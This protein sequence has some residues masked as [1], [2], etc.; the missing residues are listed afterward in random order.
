MLKICNNWW[1]SLFFLVLSSTLL[2]SLSYLLHLHSI[3]LSV[4]FRVCGIWI[5]FSCLLFVASTVVS[6][7]AHLLDQLDLWNMWGKS[8]LCNWL[9][10]QWATIL[11]LQ[12]QQFFMLIND[13]TWSFHIKKTMN[14]YN[15]NNINGS[16]THFVWSVV[17]ICLNEHFWNSIQQ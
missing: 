1:S 12:Y 2:Q 13:L 3:A 7:L 10:A 15:N 6:I 11:T 9:K 4:P 17:H 8:W 5:T 14:I 16:V